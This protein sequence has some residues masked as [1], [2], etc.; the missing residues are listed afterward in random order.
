MIKHI[1]IL[2]ILE[3]II[4]NSSIAQ[5]C[6]RPEQVF[7]LVQKEFIPNPREK[8]KVYLNDSTEVFVIRGK[9]VEVNKSNYQKLNFHTPAELKEFSL[10]IMKCEASKATNTVYVDLNQNSIFKEIYFVY[11]EESIYKMVRVEWFDPQ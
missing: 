3:I 6:H 2:F 4:S 5:N 9:V 7:I 8:S 10:E 1:T 11:K